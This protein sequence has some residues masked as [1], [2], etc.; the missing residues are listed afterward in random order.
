MTGSTALRVAV[1]LSH[2]VLWLY[3]PRRVEKQKFQIHFVPYGKHIYNPQIRFPLPLPQA[4]SLLFL[5]ANFFS[6][7]KIVLSLRSSD[8]VV[9]LGQVPRERKER[10]RGGVGPDAEFRSDF[11]VLGSIAR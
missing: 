8:A 5:L 9:P 7:P 2:I 1:L 3:F 6:A 4:P 10:Q 11:P